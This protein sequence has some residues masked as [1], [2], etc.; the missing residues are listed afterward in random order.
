M[1][2]VDSKSIEYRQ[3]VAEL[4]TNVIDGELDFFD[5]LDEIGGE[6]NVYE[7]G[8]EEVNTLIDLLEHQPTSSSNEYEDY[9]S[10]IKECISNLRQPVV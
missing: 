7:T 3:K 4:A 2:P 10:R 5:F 9:L 1:C 8:D 6:Q